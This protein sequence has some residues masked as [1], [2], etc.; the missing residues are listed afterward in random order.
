MI[1]VDVGSMNIYVFLEWIVSFYEQRIVTMVTR[2][3]LIPR[4]RSNER[5][6]ER[7]DFRY[8]IDVSWTFI[9]SYRVVYSGNEN[10][11]IRVRSN[12][13]ARER[14]VSS[15]NILRSILRAP[16]MVVFLFFLSFLRA[17]SVY[18]ARVTWNSCH[19]RTKPRRVKRKTY[20]NTRCILENMKFADAV[21]LRARYYPVVNDL[22]YFIMM[23]RI[24]KEI[25]LS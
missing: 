10:T 24:E 17:V 23:N 8:V 11:R 19:D 15:L 25:R 7:F 20:T 16:G 18:P 4:S 5:T 9:W 1:R 13:C 12:E 3:S 6:N 14:G 2:S 21:K 22:I